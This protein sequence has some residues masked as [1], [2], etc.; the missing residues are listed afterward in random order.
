MGAAI[1]NIA[2]ILSGLYVVLSCFVSWVNET[3]QSMMR[4]RGQYLYQGVL[5]LLCGHD[6]LTN[7]IFRTPFVAS[8]SNDKNG[9]IVEPGTRAAGI[10][11]LGPPRTYRPAYLE[12]R[13]FSIALWDSVRGLAGAVPEN[14]N[15][16]FKTPDALIADVKTQ[17]ATLLPG[18]RNLATALASLLNQAQDDYDK[19]LDVTDEWYNAQ[20]DRVSGWYKRYV[21]V[22]IIAISIIT[23]SL[24]GADSLRIAAGAYTSPEIAAAIAKPLAD[25]ASDAMKSGAPYANANA[26]DL[27]RAVN[28]LAALN[29]SSSA[30]P[31][32]NWKHHWGG[33]LITIAA[34]VLGGPFWFDVLRSLLKLNPRSSGD[35]PSGSA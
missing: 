21:E 25:V 28:V 20:M 33:M 29:G 15:E 17:V 23:V 31:L 22:F 4:T 13:T 16:L 11:S 19:L 6:T 14:A 30:N 12:P 5:N 18:H 24:T 32:E 3:I 1:L 7:T 2:I 27:G 8:A 35:K 34:L 9:R 10:R 26:P